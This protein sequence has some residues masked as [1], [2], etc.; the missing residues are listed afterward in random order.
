MARIIITT[1]ISPEFH[2]LAK[3]HGIKWAEAMRQGM[4]AILAE[5]GEI[6]FVNEVT[7]MKRMNVMRSQLEETSKKYYDLQEQH[8]KLIETKLKEKGVTI[9]K[10]GS[11]EAKAQA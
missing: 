9:E 11:N 8:N 6:Q 7:I 10:D 1:T 4:A 3:E 2:K 5:K